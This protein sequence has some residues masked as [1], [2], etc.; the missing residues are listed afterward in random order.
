MYPTKFKG[1]LLDYKRKWKQSFFKNGG[2][3]H[4]QDNV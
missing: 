3:M 2:Y 1:I 4:S